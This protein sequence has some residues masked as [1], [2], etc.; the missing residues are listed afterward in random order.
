MGS[1]LGRIGL[2]VACVALGAAGVGALIGGAPQT[3]PART[4][5]RFPHLPEPQTQWPG[6][7]KRDVASFL[8]QAAINFVRPGLIVKI[9]SASIASGTGVITATV[10]ITDNAGLPLDRLGI[11]TPGPVSVSFV[12]GYLPN[13]SDEYVDYASRTVTDAANGATATQAA[14]DSGGA[15]TQLA[16]GQ[17]AYTFGTKAPNFDPTTTHTIGLYASR[18]LTEFDAGTQYSNDEFSWVPNGSPVTHVH[19]LIANASCNQCHDPLAAHGGS[20]RDVALCVMCHTNQTSDPYTG[21]ALDFRVMIHKIHMGVNLPSVQ[22]GHPYQI[23][24]FQNSVNDFSDVVFPAE[25]PNNCQFCHA[26]ATQPNPPLAQANAWLTSPNRAACGA[27]HDDV[28]FATGA[29]HPGG[30][31]LNDDS[32]AQCHVP[33]GS[34]EFDASIIGAHTIARFSTQLPGIVFSIPNISN[35]APGQNPKVT[36]TLKDKSGNAISAASMNTLNLILAYPTT[37]YSTAITEDARKAAQN[38]DGSYTYTFAAALPA[39]ATGAGTIGIEGYRNQTINESQS[40]ATVRD[41]G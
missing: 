26:P 14:A 23:V 22:A 33:Q 40:Q 36:F 21:N 30:P 9:Q 28:N 12:P 34:M 35:G 38:P 2:R 11:G 20:R 10:M 5:T 32:C 17:Y 24:G 8:D 37:D 4:A 29:N 6:L 1:K 31:Q 13:N 41:V 18:N 15:W 19:S 27:C 3:Q 16:A 7:T 39:N 25:A